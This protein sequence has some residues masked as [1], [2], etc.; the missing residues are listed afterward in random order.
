ML[1]YKAAVVVYSGNGD[2]RRTIVIARR[3]EIIDDVLNFS[4]L[5]HTVPAFLALLLTLRSMLTSIPIG[6]QLQLV[7][8][9]LGEIFI[10]A[11]SFPAIN[12]LKTPE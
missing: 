7:R 12:V 5:D 4:T 9:I 10:V 8:Q 6:K 3:H 11:T 1:E 2:S